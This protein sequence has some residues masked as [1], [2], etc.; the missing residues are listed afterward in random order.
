VKSAARSRGD[1]RED[2]VAEGARERTWPT[3]PRRIPTRGPAAGAGAGLFDP[4]H[5][6]TTFALVAASRARRQSRTGLRLQAWT[7]AGDHYAIGVGI[8]ANILDEGNAFIQV[9]T[10]VDTRS[11]VD[12][13]IAPSYVRSVDNLYSGTTGDAVVDLDPG[14][15]S[16]PP[17]AYSAGPAS[18]VEADVRASAALA[19]A[20]ATP[21]LQHALGT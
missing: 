8:G 9:K 13:S 20:A 1:R 6:D 15:V 3:R 19:E 7:C 14:S 2:P 21:P 16:T 10:P 5:V 11:Y 17:Y 12:A 18:G 4:E